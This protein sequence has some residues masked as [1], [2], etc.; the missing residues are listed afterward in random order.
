M[1]DLGK[2]IKWQGKIFR[3]KYDEELSLRKPEATSLARSTAFRANVA[4]TFQNYKAALGLQQNKNK[5]DYNTV[6]GM[7][8]KPVLVL[9]TILPKF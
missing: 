1:T 4:L 7:W 8:T 2:G 3:K 6:Y 9:F 5:T